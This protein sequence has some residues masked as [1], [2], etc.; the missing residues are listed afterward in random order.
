MPGQG[1]HTHRHRRNA[2]CDET[3]CTNGPRLNRA[4]EQAAVV[5]YSQN[6]RFDNNSFRIRF[7][8]GGNEGAVSN[9]IYEYTVKLIGPDQF[10]IHIEGVRTGVS[11]LAFW[12][13]YNRDKIV[14]LTKDASYSE[15]KMQAI[16]KR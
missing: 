5:D 8:N 16:P 11:S 13:D 4:S 7:T 14:T 9:H 2:H 1:T 3:L 12:A 10:K 6:L 15:P